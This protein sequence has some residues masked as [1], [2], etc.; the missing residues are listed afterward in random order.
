MVMRDMGYT[1]PHPS[2]LNREGDG[3]SEKGL[4]M[5]CLVAP[6]PRAVV[7]LVKYGCNGE[8]KRN[9]SCANNGLVSTPLCKCNAAG[10]SNHKEYHGHDQDEDMEEE[11]DFD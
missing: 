6:A 11:E 7:E 2:L 4:P 9:C 5:N 1:S 8:C 10:C 3:W